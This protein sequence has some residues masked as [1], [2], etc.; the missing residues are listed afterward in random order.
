MVELRHS[1][2]HRR[3]GG[4]KWLTVHEMA[5]K[6]GSQQAAETIRDCKESDE[7]LSK[8]QCRFHPDAPGVVE[9]RHHFGTF[10]PTM[11]ACYK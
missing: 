1:S 3:R 10:F 2:R 8:S 9:P 6:Y 5:L 7:S 11:I 4:R